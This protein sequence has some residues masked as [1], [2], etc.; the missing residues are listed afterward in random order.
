M[1]NRL[2][3]KVANFLPASH[4]NKKEPASK[5]DASISSFEDLGTTTEEANPT[6]KKLKP[7][8]YLRDKRPTRPDLGFNA[9]GYS[10][11][12]RPKAFKPLFPG[13]SAPSG[14]PDNDECAI[15]DSAWSTRRILPLPNTS[16]L[17][18]EEIVP[19]G[20]G[21]LVQQYALARPEDEVGA[22]VRSVPIVTTTDRA[23]GGGDW[24]YVVKDKEGEGESGMRL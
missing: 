18:F 22:R 24:E 2:K 14:A 13:E 23:L 6:T 20:E 7:D 21:V 9:N 16:R 8:L 3:K 5:D 17:R 10:P 19:G 1:F 11:D 12:T 4:Q 15:D